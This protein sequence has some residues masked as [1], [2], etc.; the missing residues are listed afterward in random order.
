MEL[1]V[2]NLDELAIKAKELLAFIGDSRIV[3]ING[4]MGAGKTTLVQ[5]LLKEMGIAHPEGSPTYSLINEYDSL[6]FGK[7]YHLDLYRLKDS[8]ELYDIGIEDIIDGNS[9]CFVEWPDLLIPMLQG[10]CVVVNL[11]LE[12]NLTRKISAKKIPN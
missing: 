6:R 9:Y 7:I 10:E 3:L 11:S 12:A 5:A 4:Q 1:H 2:S 8:G